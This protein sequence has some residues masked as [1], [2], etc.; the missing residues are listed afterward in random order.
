MKRK[1]KL[2]MLTA[3]I[4][5]VAALAL[6]AVA[7]DQIQFEGQTWVCENSC[8][9]VTDENGDRSVMDGWGGWVT[10]NRVYQEFGGPMP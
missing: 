3:A 1:S 2:L 5:A 9:V 4:T 6:P 7:A 10:T 8:W